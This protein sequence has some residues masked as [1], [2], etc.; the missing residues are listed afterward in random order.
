MRIA[1]EAVARHALEMEDLERQNQ[2][3]TRE[4]SA[5]K[6][7]LHAVTGRT[8]A[9][10]TEA[11]QSR[12]NLER[13]FTLAGFET[14]HALWQ[15]VLAL[16]DESE[17]I[18]MECALQPNLDDATRQFNAGRAACASNFASHLRDQMVVARQR[19]AQMKS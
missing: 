13:W 7:R 14:D 8:E 1:V 17:R 16:A 12:T 2:Q 19:A 10:R 9:P 15:A 6:T 5:D 11:E 18:E 3:V 4:W